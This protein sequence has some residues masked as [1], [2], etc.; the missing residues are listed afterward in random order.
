LFERPYTG[1]LPPPILPVDEFAVCDEEEL[2]VYC[3]RTWEVTDGAPAKED[4]SCE[5]FLEFVRF[6]ETLSIFGW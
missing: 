3:Y 4:F 5:L 1:T 6:D 2:E